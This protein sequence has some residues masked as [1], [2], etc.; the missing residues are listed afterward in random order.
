MTG[1]SFNLAQVAA[2]INVQLASTRYDLG[3]SIPSNIR[4]QIYVQWFYF[5]PGANA[6]G[7]EATQGLEFTIL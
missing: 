4:G 3:L 5:N 2:S 1:C 7:I 6:A